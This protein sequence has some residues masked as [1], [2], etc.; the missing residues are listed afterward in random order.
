MTTKTQILDLKGI[1]YSNAEISKHTEISEQTISKILNDKIAKINVFTSKKINDFFNSNIEEIQI[2]DINKY[3]SFMLSTPDGFQRTG[4]F[5]EKGILSCWKIKSNTH[6]LIA[7]IYHLIETDLGWTTIEDISIG[8]KI[9]TDNGYESIVDKIYIG[10]IECVDIEVLHQN[11][12][13]YTNGISSHNSGKTKIAAQIASNALKL[14]NYDAIFYGDSEGGGMQSMFASANCDLS[15]IEHVP[16]LN[17]EDATVKLL[18]ILNMIKEERDIVKEK[19]APK[20]IKLEE[21]KEKLTKGGKRAEGIDKDI[22]ELEGEINDTPY[23]RGMIIVDSLGALV[24]NKVYT[25]ADKGKQVSDMG[26][27]ARLVNT[28]TKACTMPALVANVPIIYI[29]HTYDNPGEMYAGKIKNQSGGSGVQLMSSI[30][31]QCDTKQEKAEDT[32]LDTYYAGSFLRFFVTKNRLIKPFYETEA[33]IDFSK[34]VHKYQGLLD[35]ALKYGFILDNTVKNGYYTIP[36]WGDGATLIR[37]DDIFKPEFSEAWDTF[38]GLFDEKSAKDMAYS[39]ES[40]A[41]AMNAKFE[42]EEKSVE[43]IDFIDGE[44]KIQ[45]ESIIVDNVELKPSL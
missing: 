36:T 31:I 10:E 33:F 12:R 4:A 35:P 40:E 28:L 19:L 9:L 38:I 18:S 8:S 29:N 43:L 2:G 6:E 14:H 16:L 39:S 13:Y 11:H 7:S 42:A 44:E 25:D 23:F 17:V 41:A 32:H 30:T 34:G 27:R 24:T 21:L 22:L 15:K 45:S 5:F 3:S 26:S 37:K 1:G 20:Y